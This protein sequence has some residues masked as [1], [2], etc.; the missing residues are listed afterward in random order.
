MGPA[1]VDTF[2]RYYEV[3]GYG[4]AVS[5]DLQRR[6]GLADHARELGRERHR[7]AARR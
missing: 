3:P 4:H 2:V 5:I 1:E 6:L 7:A